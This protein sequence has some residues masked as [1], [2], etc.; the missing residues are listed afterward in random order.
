METELE[1]ILKHLTLRQQRLVISWHRKAQMFADLVDDL[2]ASGL[3]EYKGSHYNCTRKALIKGKSIE[4]NYRIINYN[5]MAVVLNTYETKRVEPREYL[6]KHF[7]LRE[8]A[9]SY[10]KRES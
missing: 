4:Y 8:R 2:V 1:L 9:G 3:V 7:G 6:E 10:G 5:T